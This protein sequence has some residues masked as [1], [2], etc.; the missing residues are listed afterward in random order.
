MSWLLGLSGES[1]PGTLRAKAGD[2]HGPPLHLIDSPTLF[3]SA[4][5]LKE[6]CIAGNSGNLSGQNH[7]WIVV[8]LGI[9]LQGDSCRLLDS[10]DWAKLLSEESPEPRALDGHF[11]ALRWNNHTLECWTDKLGLRSLYIVDGGSWTAFST[12][13]D[14]LARLT[15]NNEIDFG[16]FGSRWLTFNQISTE[17]PIRGIRRVGPGGYVKISR[18]RISITN[19]LWQPESS[20]CSQGQFEKTLKAF[21]NPIFSD[22]V[23]LSLGLSGGLDSRLLF[24]LLLSKNE[25]FFVHTFGHPDDPDVITATALARHNGI[26]H[27]QFQHSHS[28]FPELLPGLN[29]YIGQTTATEPASSYL[30]LQHYAKLNA[31]HKVMIDG[32]FGEITRRQYFNRLRLR[33]HTAL[34]SRNTAAMLPHLC[35]HRAD[36]FTD[37][38][39]QQMKLGTMEQ[40]SE[41]WD[42]MPANLTDEDALDVFAIR[43]RFPNFGGYE[44]PRLDGEVVNYMPFAQST[45]LNCMFGLPLSL[46][47]NASFHRLLIKRDH[48]SLTKYPLVKG[49]TT[50]PFG[51]SSTQA[52]AW[53]MIK[54]RLGMAIVDPSRNEFLESL[55]QFILDTAHSESVKSY[56]AYDYGKILKLVNGYYAG[57]KNLAADVDWWLAFE[58]WRQS[59]DGICRK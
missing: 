4:G 36:V 1:I 2:I 46:R 48:A 12:R 42:C 24:S 50:Y 8:G 39:N 21:I 5:G 53:T 54:S 43:T 13:L 16:V 51:L 11:V 14:W 33:G 37:D 23:D 58:L 32:G 25:K 19:Q 29:E 35:I 57:Q 44:Q 3:L 26:Q 18:G 6:T 49:G 31:Q 40:L 38:V 30:R 45:L 47:Q 15:G 17:A 27:S 22:G 10:T 55:S 34:R 9:K 56:P 59:V 52:I 28:A 41:L 20:S 7:N